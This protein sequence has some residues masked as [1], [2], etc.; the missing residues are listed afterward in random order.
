MALP[1]KNAQDLCNDHFRDVCCVKCIRSDTTIVPCT[2]AEKHFMSLVDSLQDCGLHICQMITDMHSM[3][4]N[5]SVRRHLAGALA[6]T[7]YAHDTFGSGSR[8]YTL[9]GACHRFRGACACLD[10]IFSW[11]TCPHVASV[12]A[13]GHGEH[14]DLFIEVDTVMSLWMRESMDPKPL[15]AW[16]CPP[17]TKYR[18]RLTPSNPNKV[19][20]VRV[21]PFYNSLFGQWRRWHA[22]WARVTWAL[23]AAFLAE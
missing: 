12:R 15:A 13:L 1:R 14:G 18:C 19:M 6:S 22:R 10:N 7:L 5:G 8:L 17:W 11:G 2:R 9:I 21:D 23:A 20:R 16:G 4:V 3:V